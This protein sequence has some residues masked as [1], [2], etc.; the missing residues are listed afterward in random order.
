[1]SSAPVAGIQTRSRRREQIGQ[2][3]PPPPPRPLPPGTIRQRRQESSST[4]TQ[5]PRSTTNDAQDNGETPDNNLNRASGQGHQPQDDSKSDRAP[6]IIDDWFLY[7]RYPTKFDGSR[8][9]QVHISHDMTADT[10]SKCLQQV[11]ASGSFDCQDVIAVSCCIILWKNPWG[12]IF[13]SCLTHSIH[14]IS[15]QGLF[16]EDNRIF[17]SL[18]HILRHAPESRNFTFSILQPVFIPK[19]PTKWW[20]SPWFWVPTTILVSVATYFYHSD[21]FN[22]VWQLVSDVYHFLFDLPLRE[23]YRYGPYM[24]GWEGSTLP[25]ICSRITYHGDRAFWAR[26]MNECHLIYAGKE[27]SFLRIAR[28]TVYSILAIILFWAVRYLVQTYADGIRMR[29]ADRD[30]HETYRALNILL[31][32]LNRMA[33]GGD[34]RHG[35]AH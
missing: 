33:G 13:G 6:A 26:N 32:H 15:L 5:T 23:L 21:I 31:R 27:E 16:R 19:P 3:G 35:H 20:Q 29:A 8:M 18:D 10:L 25:E 34:R 9:A 4:P 2:A 7:V 17:F 22:F 28:P 1:M 12:L 30:M 11:A 14:S 24:I